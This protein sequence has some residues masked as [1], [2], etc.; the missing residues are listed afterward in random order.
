LISSLKT[1]Q[2]TESNAQT[3]RRTGIDQLATESGEVECYTQ[4]YNAGL[5][6]R[7]LYCLLD[8]WM[9]TVHALQV[10]LAGCDDLSR[11][12]LAM[13]DLMRCFRYKH[14]PYLLNFPGRK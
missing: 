1:P 5:P 7:L 8:L 11:L 6:Q 13:V 2:P 3:I 12:V 10:R 4:G 9:Q 14:L